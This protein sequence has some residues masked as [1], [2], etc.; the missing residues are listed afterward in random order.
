M[1]EENTLGRCLFNDFKRRNSER[2][3]SFQ[4]K[5]HIHSRARASHEELMTK[6]LFTAMYTADRMIAVDRPFYGTYA[7]LISAS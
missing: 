7:S 6:Y 5:V 4:C 3:L 1:V 2:T